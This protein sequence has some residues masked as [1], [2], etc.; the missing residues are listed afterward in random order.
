M[1][2]SWIFN[3]EFALVRLVGGINFWNF[4]VWDKFLAG[5]EKPKK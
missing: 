4:L 1:N 3:Y 5:A 2:N